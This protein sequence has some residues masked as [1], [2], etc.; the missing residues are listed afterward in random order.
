MK[1]L[2]TYR[3]QYTFFD[4]DVGQLPITQPGPSVQ[5]QTQ[6]KDPFKDHLEKQQQGAVIQPKKALQKSS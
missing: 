2:D 3:Q 6:S 1:K 4:K 5:P